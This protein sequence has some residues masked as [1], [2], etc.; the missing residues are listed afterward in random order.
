MLVCAARPPSPARGLSLAHALSQEA[1]ILEGFA[2]SR[3]VAW[4]RSRPGSG[5]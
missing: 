3:S 5:V 4:E 2:S 1:G